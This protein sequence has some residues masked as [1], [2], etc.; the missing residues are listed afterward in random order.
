MLLFIIYDYYLFSKQLTIFF[1]NNLIY[2]RNNINIF[3]S[4]IL[5]VLIILLIYVISLMEYQLITEIS[6]FCY[7]Q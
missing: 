1:F 4:L 3:V 7:F 5:I 2:L 6:N